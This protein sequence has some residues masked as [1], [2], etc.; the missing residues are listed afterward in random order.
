MPYIGVSPQFGVRRK[1]TYT[2]TASQTS[3][4]G[5]GAE[6][7]TLSY[8]DSNF[9]DVYQNG[10][11]LGDADYTST[12]GTAIVLG[13]GATANDIIE[14][15]VFDAF[16][17]A[18][19]VSKADGGQFDGNVTMAGTLGVTGAV[20]ADAGISIDNITIDG[21]EIDL[22][23]GNLTLDVAGQLVINSDSGQIVL[24]DDTVNWGNLQNSSGD[25]VIESLGTD[26]DIIFKGLDGSSTIEA[27]RIDMSSGGFVGIGT[28]SPLHQLQNEGTSYF[29]DNVFIA[30]GI[31]K[32]VS[33][34]SSSNPL[35]FG[36]N[37]NE[38]ARISSAGDVLI[39]RTSV[40]TDFGDGRTSLV[41]QG[42]G[43]QD[44]ATIQI[45]N[46]GTAS[47]TQILGILAFYDGTSN[48][49]RVQSIRA[50]AADSAHL[51]F[52]TR[53]NGGSLT[54]RMRVTNGGA[55]Q[56]GGTSYHKTGDLQV[57]DAA[58][59]KSVD[60]YNSKAVI[61]AY[62]EADTNGGI[63]IDFLNSSGGRI[64]SVKRNGTSGV[65]YNTSS[66]YRLK[67]NVSYEFD[68]TTRLKQLKPCRFNWIADEKNT[69]ID[70]FIA[71]EV[72]SIVPEAVSGEKDALEV[73]K[74]GEELPDGVSVGDNK[75]DEDG[76]TIINPQGIDQAKLVPL[77]TKT[78]QEALTRIDALEAEVK[79]LKGE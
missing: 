10:V 13:T 61:V 30:G 35:I 51:L 40:L 21:T 11:K 63:Y 75:L 28:D 15:I 79:K 9:V 33:S 77:L 65:S 32:M 72:S 8:T 18:D 58:V 29:K 76:K 57:D 59:F 3:F 48:N 46:N 47:N 71:H 53:A 25:F 37:A 5:A 45:G 2:A 6:G 26:K 12:S 55:V 70:G 27:M 62:S 1:H 38:K 52:S 56:I 66:D 74:S 39:G 14:I 41:L 20:T 42:T 4:S 22:S 78:L 68:A 23:S 69:T 34:D 54:E 64:G 17:A 24:Q 19:T 43:S 31:N 7:A 36:I 50:D 67:E 16:S 44:Y 73:W 60:Y 49:A